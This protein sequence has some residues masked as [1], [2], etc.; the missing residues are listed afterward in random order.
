MPKISVVIE[1]DS[2]DD[3]MWL[4]PDNVA[5][6]LA[7]YCKNTKFSVSWDKNGNPWDVSKSSMEAQN[8]TSTNNDS[9]KLLCVEAMEV[10]EMVDK[11][12]RKTD[13]LYDYAKGAKSQLPNVS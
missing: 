5:L 7:A 12:C 6:A 10:S 2:P 13:N 1:Y 11:L 4:N 3:P 8:S 9:L